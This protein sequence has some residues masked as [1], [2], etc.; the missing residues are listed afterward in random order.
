MSTPYPS[1]S[2]IVKEGY[3]PE[4]IPILVIGGILTTLIICIDIRVLLEHKKYSVKHTMQFLCTAGILQVYPLFCLMYFVGTLIPKSLG[5]CSFIAESYEAISFL[6][7]LRLM[8][9][10]IGGKKALKSR[11]DGELAHL[12][13]PP[14]CCLVCLPH[15]HFSDRLYH[16]NELCIIQFVVVQLVMG[17]ANMLQ[18][19]DSSNGTLLFEVT[20]SKVYHATFL[21]SLLIAIYGLSGIYHAAEADLADKNIFKKFISYKIPV[22]LAKIQDVL[23]AFLLYYNAFGSIKSGAFGN[24]LRATT[25]FSLL[26]IVECFVMF[27]FAVQFYNPGDYPNAPKDAHWFPFG[28]SRIAVK[29]NDIVKKSEINSRAELVEATAE[30]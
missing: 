19:L 26:T 8:L 6:F 17:F 4:W 25:W 9:T 30:M 3:P 23:C 20:L 12:N 11:L 24:S 1:I 15:V 14:C 7:F 29:D 22:S 10:Y 27:L 5:V 13:V 28:G 16:V 2:T 18:I 21:V